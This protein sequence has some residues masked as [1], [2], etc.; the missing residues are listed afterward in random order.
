MSTVNYQLERAFKRVHVD[1]HVT[2]ASEGYATHLNLNH[3]S[4]LTSIIPMAASES[5]IKDLSDA[6]I[7]VSFQE[8]GDGDPLMGHWLDQG[9]YPTQ[10]E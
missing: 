2:L 1:V 3:Q 9:V 8:D 4:A 6:F 10:S 7:K 5:K